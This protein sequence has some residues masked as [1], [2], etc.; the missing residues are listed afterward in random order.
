M[1]FVLIALASMLT[2]SLLAGP[3]FAQED[4]KIV[5]KTKTEIDFEDVDVSGELM[6][7]LLRRRVGA[8]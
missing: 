1:R 8:P 6:G 2:F 5:Y 3:A 4:R 7:D